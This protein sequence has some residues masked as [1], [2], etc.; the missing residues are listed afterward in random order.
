[1]KKGTYLLAISMLFASVSLFAQDNDRYTAAMEKM[2]SMLDA[3]ETAEDMQKAANSFERIANAEQDKW[4]PLYYAAYSNVMLA[5]MPTD[6]KDVDALL[7]KAD[8]QL[9]KAATISVDNSE[10]LVLESMS[11][12]ARMQVD[13]QARAMVYGPKSGTL[14]NKARELDEENPRAWMQIGQNTFYTP[15]MWGGGKEKGCKLL[16]TAKEKYTSYEATSSIHPDWG[17]EYLNGIIEQGCQ[18]DTHDHD[19]GDHEGHDH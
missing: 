10:I 18:G 7:D 17:E 8:A 6:G 4:L 2:I 5:F 3:S 19:H 16:R 12:S 13:P 9:E 15:E 11:A 1:M 14:A